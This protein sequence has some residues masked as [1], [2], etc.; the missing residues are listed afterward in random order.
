MPEKK[1]EAIAEEER[2]VMSWWALAREFHRT[3]RASVG[4]PMTG[5]FWQHVHAAHKEQILAV[6]SLLDARL[7]QID[8]RQK[9]AERKATKIAV[10]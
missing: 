8:E 2:E 9:K 4:V 3:L 5:E 10:Q 1:H 6:R 7:A